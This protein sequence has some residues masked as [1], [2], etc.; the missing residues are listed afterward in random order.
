M[1]SNWTPN[2]LPSLK[3]KTAIVTKDETD[4]I[5]RSSISCILQEK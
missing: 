5:R 3:G 2:D 4:G 1:V